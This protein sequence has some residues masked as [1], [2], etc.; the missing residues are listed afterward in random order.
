MINAKDMVLEAG[1][2]LG[3]NFLEPR[4]D[5]EDIKRIQ[6]NFPINHHGKLGELYW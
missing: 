3:P 2:E 6:A 4:D 1:R 5:L